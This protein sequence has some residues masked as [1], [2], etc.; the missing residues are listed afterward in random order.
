MTAVTHLVEVQIPN[1][2]RETLFMVFMVFALYLQLP[3]GLRFHW[4]PSRL[5][6]EA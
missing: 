2:V 3:I 1:M 5:I 6:V 4:F